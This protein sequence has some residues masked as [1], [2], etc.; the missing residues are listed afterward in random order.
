MVALVEIPAA[1]PP[2]GAL[3]GSKKVCMARFMEWWSPGEMLGILGD[4]SPPVAEM[5]AA[6]GVDDAE[7]LSEILYTCVGPRF[8]RTIDDDVAKRQMF[9]ERML[10]A[11]V[12]RGD[13]KESDILDEASGAHYKQFR[14]MAEVAEARIYDGWCAR[15]ALRLGLPP[16][17]AKKEKSPKMPDTEVVEPHSPLNPLY[18]YQYTAGLLVRGMLEGREI[19]DKGGGRPIKRRL[20]AVP[21]GSGK[22]RMIVETLIEWLNDGKPSRSEQQA[23][24][25]FIVWV[26]QTEELCE[27]AV[28][29]FRDVFRALGKRGTTL[30]LHRFWGQAGRLP[31]MEMSDLLDERAVIVATMQSLDKVLKN[32]P[33][34]LDSLARLTSCI[35]IDEAH[36]STARSYS[37]VLRK[38]HFNWDNRKKEISELG[39]VLIGLTATPFRGT[40]GAVEKTNLKRRYGDIVYPDIPYY[41]GGSGSGGRNQLPHA[42]IDCQPSA[43]AGDSIRILGERSYDRD[44]YIRDDGYAWTIEKTRPFIS[45]Y[46]AA[47]EGGEAGKAMRRSGRNIVVR[48]DD[49]G[50]YK[51]TLAVTDNEGDTGSA[52]AYLRIRDT[53][54]GAQG[55]ADGEETEVQKRLYHRLIKRKILCDVS[56]RILPSVVIPLTAKDLK[57]VRQYGEFDPGTIKGIGN[58]PDRNRLI[59]DTIVE[60][61]RTHGRKK[62]LFFGCSV[63]HSRLIAVLLKALHGIRAAYVDSRTDA[64]SRATAIEGFRSGDLEVLCNYG[65]LTAGFDAPNIDC[66]FVGRPVRS[67]LLYTQMIGRGMRGT[68][69]GGTRDM[70]IIDIDD[71]FQLDDG[72][73]ELPQ[74]V[75]W[76][77]YRRYWKKWGDGDGD[78]GAGDRP[79]GG[80]GPSRDPAGAGPPPDTDAPAPDPGAGPPA[81]TAGPAGAAGDAGT[82]S[83]RAGSAPAATRPK[84]AIDKEFAYLRDKEY[85]HIPTSR[86]FRAR[87]PRRV[88]DDVD[89]QY[90][91]YAAYLESR[92]LALRDDPD[93]RDRLYEAYFSLYL[94]KRAP[95][96][97]GDLDLGGDYTAADY[98]EC[99]GD[100]GRFQVTIDEIVGRM[101]LLDTGVTR[102]SLFRDYRKMR[103]D[104]G[105]RAPHF[106]EVRRMSGLGI[107]YY[108]GLFGTMTEFASAEEYDRVTTLREVEAAHLSLAGL[109]GLAPN[110]RQMAE[111]AATSYD[112]LDSL[113]PG[114]DRAEAYARFMADV[115]IAET[116]LSD[117]V[118]PDVRAKMRQRAM[119]RFKDATSL[120]RGAD[121]A[122]TLSRADVLSA[123][124]GKDPAPYEEWFGSVDAFADALVS[125]SCSDED[126]GGDDLAGGPPAT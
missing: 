22:T 52:S 121:G 37:E 65:V 117:P 118:P 68:R 49:P 108:L 95:L 55:A 59:L 91:G 67:T 83:G 51:I 14:T 123:L 5:L 41:D 79:P 3:T 104:C 54:R 17:T 47:G 75:G 7:R 27:Q 40:G 70:V 44:G 90:G 66:V 81:D 100:Y 102:A 87:A 76:K 26:A 97:R 74:E 30:R 25:K 106:D 82:G 86:Q 12:E 115:G 63:D 46:S 10:R 9:L 109:L 21:T 32:D 119:R 53:P 57:R 58:M 99:F 13:E 73:D 111:H 103:A 6:H 69:S 62:I 105:G 19:D 39:I 29:S 120:R 112:L 116:P 18:D 114:Q 64:S 89:R 16:S 38:M 126:K 88:V 4:I 85:G 94:R 31:P 78:G 20:I 35:V 24:S 45:M 50:E 124:L 92:G 42:L 96:S 113:Y 15:L 1:A 125:D 72:Q 107:E 101:S 98:E 84:T 34:Q 71:N 11:A 28:S 61:N 36:H 2:S 80:A 48:L 110:A 56:H 33:G 122:S 23:R 43:H 77:I 60:M 93:L 8:L